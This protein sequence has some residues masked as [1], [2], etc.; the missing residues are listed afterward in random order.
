MI[1]AGTPHRGSDKA[2]WASI[3]TN[4]AAVV[5]KDHSSK[6]SR[7]LERGSSTLE[8]LQDWFRKIQ[9]HFHV[10]TFVEDVPCP[11]IGKIVEADSAVI[12]C[13]H[14]KKRLI[15]AN[16]VEMVRFGSE[17][18]NEYKKVKDAFRQIHQHIS[19]DEV[20]GVGQPGRLDNHR[21]SYV[22]LP[23][24]SQMRYSVGV[25]GES[26]PRL[27]IQPEVSTFQQQMN[28]PGRVNT[29]RSR[30]D[31]ALSPR[32]LS[33]RSSGASSPKPSSGRLVNR[34][35]TTTLRT[36]ESGTSRHSSNQSIPHFRDQEAP[37]TDRSGYCMSH[38]PYGSP[39]LLRD[40]NNVAPAVRL[41]DQGKVFVRQR[42]RNFAKNLITAS[43]C[44]KDALGLLPADADRTDFAS[45][46]YQL[47]GVEFE[48][49]YH[50]DMT[51][52]E[53][54]SH[55][56]SAEQYGWDASYNARQSTNAGLLAQIQLYM[57]IIKGRSAEVNERLGV[58]AQEIRR[59]K[60]DTLSEIAIAIE[61]VRELRPAKLQDSEE[62]AATWIK[63]LSPPTSSP[64]AS[65]TTS[66]RSSVASSMSN[67]SSPYTMTTPSAA[68]L[69]AHRPYTNTIPPFAELDT[70]GQ[71][72]SARY[73][74]PEYTS[75][76]YAP[77]GL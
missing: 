12:S 63:R 53:K 50:R 33:H 62:F 49:A 39:M 17:H 2:K 22:R 8:E 6:M 72:T 15:H 66:T 10:F 3:A 20:Q 74:H 52:Q 57:A 48:M 42:D 47:M 27:S 55:L 77:G 29:V 28:D 26:R 41:V 32:Q 76:L 75:P 43:Q 73:L 4:L 13:D 34:A 58:G 24:G 16:H 40:A 60:D 7:A 65:N 25:M 30:E 9:N 67:L 1:F 46:Q 69:E 21:G 19:A 44:F 11:K 61:K 68:E 56:R 51:P 54:L 64:P 14:E 36:V 38:R 45:T 59:Q 37:N 70:S 5:H 71:L 18:C 23:E 31:I 35:S